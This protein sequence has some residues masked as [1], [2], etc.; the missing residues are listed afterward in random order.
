M[1][2]KGIKFLTPACI[3]MHSYGLKDIS[4]AI[5]KPGNEIFIYLNEKGKGVEIDTFSK[6]KRDKEGVKEKVLKFANS[7]LEEIN[8]ELGVS[9]IIYNRIPF[10]SGLGLLEANITGVVM[11]MNELLKSHFRK[12][13][14]FNFIIKKSSDLNIDISESGI[15]AN[16]FGGIILYNNNLHN[17]IQKLYTPHGVNLSIINYRNNITSNNLGTISVE[18]LFLQSKNNATFI[19]SL[20]T[21]DHDLLSK[22]LK[23]NIFEERIAKN[24]DWF[25]DIK[26]I[27]YSN[28]VYALGFSHFGES[29]FILN[30][31]TLIK[32]INHNQLQ[33]YFDSK[34]IKIDLIETEFNLN[35]LIKY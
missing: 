16:L 25:E 29:I 15:A 17:P 32:D 18:D 19:K 4:I 13:E 27:S 8:S 30:P 21:S 7:F 14:L 33:D 1:K 22:S 10:L 34:N 9:L 2:K 6:E 28:G 26:K 23:N 31:N 3:S 11:A 12:L 35:G 20:L 5:D 24:I